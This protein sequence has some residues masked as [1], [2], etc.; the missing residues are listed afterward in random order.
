MQ[1]VVTCRFDDDGKLVAA[2][3]GEKIC[4]A[5]DGAYALAALGGEAVEAQ[6]VARDF[7]SRQPDA[8]SL[9]KHAR[10]VLEAI[11][12][13]WR[14]LQAATGRGLGSLPV[15]TV[16]NQLRIQPVDATH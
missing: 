12:H 15:S 9:A 1:R 10:A 4:R 2:K 13:G 11:K 8:S 5:H 16:R 3:A 6:E 7:R 14:S